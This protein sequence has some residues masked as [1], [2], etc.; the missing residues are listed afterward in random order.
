MAR[1]RQERERERMRAKILDAA[2]DL[3]VAQGYE[4]ATMRGIAKEMGGYSA[5]T[6]YLYFR[7]KEA[8]LRALCDADF[9][10]LRGAFDRI[11]RVA[12]P[13]ERLREIGRAY[14]EFALKYPNHYRFMFMTERPTDDPKKQSIEHG[15]PDQDVYA[16]VHEA[17]AAAIAARRLRPECRDAHLVTQLLWSVVHGLVSLRMTHAKDAWVEFRSVKESAEALIDVVVRGLTAKGA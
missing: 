1:V 15:N 5:T 16:F 13:V 2:R 10:A 17:V 14:V 11:A 4:A 9:L 12:D 6:L 7:D 3:F 8:I